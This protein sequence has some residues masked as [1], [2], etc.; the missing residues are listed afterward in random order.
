MDS[1]TTALGSYLRAGVAMRH[2]APDIAANHIRAALAAVDWDERACAVENFGWSIYV[3]SSLEWMMAYVEELDID[4]DPGGRIVISEDTWETLAYDDEAL[5]YFL[6]E[7][8]VGGSGMKFIVTDAGPYARAVKAE[9][10]AKGTDM[11]MAKD[12]LTEL[13]ERAYALLTQAASLNAAPTPVQRQTF[14]VRYAKLT[15]D[16][17]QLEVRLGYLAAQIELAGTALFDTAAG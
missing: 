14:A 2:N 12:A 13:G 11:V 8:R 4:G 6:D 17:A 3:D 15:A 9:A 16:F 7:M 5:D 1:L 10:K